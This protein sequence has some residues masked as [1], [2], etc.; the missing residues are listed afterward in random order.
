MRLS[1]KSAVVTGGSGGI[2][3]PLV[4]LLLAEG[5]TVTV[6]GRQPPASAVAGY[7]AADLA[8]S[9]G[10][11]TACG[12]VEEISPDMLVCL[13]GA[14]YFGPFAEQPSEEIDAAYRVNLL[15]PTQLARAALSSMLKRRSGHVLFAGSVF[16]ALPFAHFATYSSAKAGLAAMILALRREYDGC[17][18][19]FT[20]AVPRAVRTSMASET[21]RR[22]ADMAGFRLDA[23]ED[24]ARRIA[25]VLMQGGGEVAPG[26]P[27]SLLMRLN[28]LSP[29]LT[30]RALAGSN[31]KA[32]KLLSQTIRSS[33]Q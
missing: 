17:G 30:S 1:G 24:V 31:R 2:G 18:I 21:I 22:F 12:T 32:R 16:G 9:E 5:A 14:Q 8:S 3:A 6:I 29:A 27:E 25:A 26:F 23:P 11:S 13:A 4:S 7:V 10:L 33:H 15:A 28:A 19:T 20:C